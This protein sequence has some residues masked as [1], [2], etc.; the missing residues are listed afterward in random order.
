VKE[1]EPL[2]NLLA[3]LV[4]KCKYW[5][6]TCWFDTEACVVGTHQLCQRQMGQYSEFDGVRN[7][8]CRAGYV[9]CIY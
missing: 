7:C 6:A 4:Q 2:L 1:R 3:L 9:V 8:R 5:R